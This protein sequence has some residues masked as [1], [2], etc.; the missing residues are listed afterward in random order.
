M[1]LR[2]SSTQNRPEAW[3]GFEAPRVLL[4]VTW[5][6]AVRVPKVSDRRCYSKDTSVHT[7]PVSR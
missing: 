6:G 3:S 5:G 7:L 1:E 2:I 4:W